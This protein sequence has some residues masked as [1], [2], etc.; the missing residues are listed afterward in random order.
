MMWFAL[1][2]FGVFGLM[3]LAI[4]HRAKKQGKA[5][6]ISQIHAQAAINAVNATKLSTAINHRDPVVNRKELLDKWAKK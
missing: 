1:V 5:E 3:L 4:Q 6:A 2:A